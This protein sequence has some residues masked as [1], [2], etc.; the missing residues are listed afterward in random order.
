LSLAAAAD[1]ARAATAAL[2]SHTL[3]HSIAATDLANSYTAFL[4][5]VN[6][7]SLYRYTYTAIY[8]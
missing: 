3:I 8:A 4:Y 1:A 7:L 2:T 5:V 6:G